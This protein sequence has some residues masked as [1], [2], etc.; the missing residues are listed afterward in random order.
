MTS[1]GQIFNLDSKHFDRPK[2]GAGHA[3]AMARSGFKEMGQALKAFP[4]SID[5][6]EEYGLWGS[7][8]PSEIAEDR[9]GPKLAGQEM[10]HDMQLEM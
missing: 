2:I 7:K 6:Q 8:L 3:Q 1:V 10:G 4:E 9:A 5:I